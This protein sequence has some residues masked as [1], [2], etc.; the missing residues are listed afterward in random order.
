MSCGRPA[1]DCPGKRSCPRAAVRVDDK[2]SWTSPRG[3]AALEGEVLQR[4][5]R[6][7]RGELTLYVRLELVHESLVAEPNG[8]GHPSCPER[9]LGKQA[10]A[11]G[12]HKYDLAANRVDPVDDR[13]VHPRVSKLGAR[14]EKSPICRQDVIF[15]CGCRELGLRSCARAI[16]SVRRA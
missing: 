9:A 11:R 6:L 5:R 8:S 4:R 12:V 7:R 1:G 3:A 15:G 2:L 13:F 10:Q 14:T 16:G